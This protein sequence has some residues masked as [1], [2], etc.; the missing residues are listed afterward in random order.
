MQPK[1]RRPA[2]THACSC[3]RLRSSTACA[4]TSE[5]RRGTPAGPLRRP[6]PQ[7]RPRRIQRPALPRPDRTSRP[8]PAA[9]TGRHSP[10]RQ[11][12]MPLPGLRGGH[13]GRHR[14]AHVGPHLPSHRMLQDTRARARKVHGAHGG[15]RPGLLPQAPLSTRRAPPP[16]CVGAG[17]QAPPSPGP[18]PAPGPAQH[19]PRPRPGFGSP[20]RTGHVRKPPPRPRAPPPQPGHLVC[21]A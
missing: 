6:R 21:I 11:P 7:P 20:L 9:R 8:G 14:P 4:G 13:R 17:L 12:P 3:H 16:V 19:R 18:R 5:G 2:T 1:R 10:R 15:C